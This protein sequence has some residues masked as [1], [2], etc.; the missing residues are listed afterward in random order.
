MKAITLVAIAQ[1]IALELEV[2]TVTIDRANASGQ[3]WSADVAATYGGQ[4]HIVTGEGASAEVAQ[5]RAL[6]L[7]VKAALPPPVLAELLAAK[8]ARGKSDRYLADLRIRLGRFANDWPVDIGSIA[9]PDIQG[10]LDRLKMAPRSVANFRTCLGTL[11]GFAESRG[12]VFEAATRLR[13]LNQ[14]KSAGT[15][16]LRSTPPRN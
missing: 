9:G 2:V 16:S 10:W 15:A 4:R 14:S 6:A 3:R 11:F 5:M 8:E 7:A 12:Y 13:R 1:S